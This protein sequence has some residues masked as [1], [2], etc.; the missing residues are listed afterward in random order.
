[1]AYQ[2]KGK[3]KEENANI[4]TNPDEL[5]KF[6]SVLVSITHYLQIIDDQKEAIKETVEEAATIYSIDKR[7]IRKLANTMYKHNYADIQEENK[8]FELLYETLVGGRLNVPDPLEEEEE[9]T[10]EA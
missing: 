3:K 5:K 4:L 7:I 9:E 2:K 6:K 1:M 8:H 10:E